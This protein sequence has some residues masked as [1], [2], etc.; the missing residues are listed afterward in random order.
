MSVFMCDAFGALPLLRDAYVRWFSANIIRRLNRSILPSS[1]LPVCLANSQAAI[2]CDDAI[3]LMLENKPHIIIQ[4]NQAYIK[5]INQM[6]SAI[7]LWRMNVY[8]RRQWRATTER[9]RL[10][11]QAASGLLRCWLE[12]WGPRWVLVLCTIT[13]WQNTGVFAKI[14]NQATEAT[15]G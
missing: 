6:H 9:A 14:K 10:L 8:G 11:P 15:N 1:T 13:C 2:F 3:W 4:S 7:H 12:A 5:S